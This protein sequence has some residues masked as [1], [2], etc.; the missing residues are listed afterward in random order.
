MAFFGRK[1]VPAFAET[2]AGKEEKKT[3]TTPRVSKIPTAISMG[4]DVSHVLRHARITEKA[5]MHSGAGVY[6]FDV[7][8][9]ATKRDIVEAIRALYKVTPRKVAV[10]TIPAKVRRSVRTGKVGTKRGGRKAYIYL[11]KGETINLS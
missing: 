6:T 3:V 10:V 5:T 1:N 8:E 11:K 2:P 7:G 4:R 9:R